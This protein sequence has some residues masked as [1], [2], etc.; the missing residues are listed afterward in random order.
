MRSPR[1][2]LFVGKTRNRRITY[3]AKAAS[4]HRN[5]Y[6]GSE[7]NK[8]FHRPWFLYKSAVIMYV[9]HR[10]VPQFQVTQCFNCYD[11]GH[12]AVNHERVGNVKG[13]YKDHE[14][15]TFIGI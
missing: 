13:Y 15:K 5:L 6:E 11:Y 12:R 14:D 7:S 1:L 9:A 3:H 10:F 2:H 8:S 4:F